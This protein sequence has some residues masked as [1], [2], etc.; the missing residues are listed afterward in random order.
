V[1]GTLNTYNSLPEPKSPTACETFNFTSLP[2]G[3]SLKLN[4]F[5]L[6]LFSHLKS[7]SSVHCSLSLLNS[8]LPSNKI[9]FPLPDLGKYWNLSNWLKLF[10][11]TINSNGTAF[12]P[13]LVCHILPSSKS[14][15]LSTPSDP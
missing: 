5:I 12:C 4:S 14:T 13:H 2:L 9:P 7:P 10:K 3:C 1:P 15:K 6:S 11:S 8:T